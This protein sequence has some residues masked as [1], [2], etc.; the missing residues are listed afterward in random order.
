[1]KTLRITESLLC[2]ALILFTA[3]QGK[4]AKPITPGSEIKFS[5]GAN[6][7]ETDT[8]AAYSGV[9]NS[10]GAIERID[11][12]QGDLIRIYCAAVSEPSVKY[13]DYVVTEVKS[14]SDEISK[15]KIG[16]TS[17]GELG[18]RWSNTSGTSHTFYAVYPSPDANGI[19]KSIEGSTVSASLPATQSIAGSVS[20]SGLNHTANP[21]LKNM[22]MTAK[23]GPYKESEGIPEGDDVFLSFTP[24]TTAI[25]FTI[26]NRTKDA[27]TLKSV[28]LISA[29]YPLNG[30]FTVNIDSQSTPSEINLGNTTISYS[31][32]Y[33]ECNYTGGAATDA[34]RTVTINF[35][36]PVTLA[37]DDDVAKCGTL[38][39]TFFL[40]PCRN[41]DDLTFKLVKSDDS[42]M[43]TRLGYTDGS[44]ILFPCFKK[45]TVTGLLVPEGAQWRVS[46][47]PDVTPWDAEHGELDD[48]DLNYPGGATITLMT[49]WEEGESATIDMVLPVV[50]FVDLGLPSGTLW[51]D[52]NVGAASET[53]AGDYFA[54]G[55]TSPRAADWATSKPYNWANTPFNN[56]IADYDATYFGTNLS[57]WVDGTTL[58]PEYDAAYVAYG[59][60]AHIPTSSDYQELM[61][62]C[63]ITWT[64]DFEG[65]GVKGFICTSNIAGYTDQYIFLPAAGRRKDSGIS[66]ENENLRYWT[67]TLATETTV[68]SS[69]DMSAAWGMFSE[70]T[71]MQMD[72]YGDRYYGLSVRAVRN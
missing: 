33:P 32:A 8:K 5:A 14:S 34:T 45:S 64:N 68:H 16:H 41:F 12:E 21:D 65:T 36:S 15:A 66:G 1:M 53:D 52:R 71:E 29:E 40:Q 49:A 22:L 6:A 63:T 47:G 2:M 23:A 42:W 11:W 48:I 27:L 20:V 3:C 55:E 31:R 38:T 39:F 35:S 28:S 67:S 56:G 18:L 7:G 30:A 19:A 43:S 37:Y 57:N 50:T 10:A 54:W 13:A 70:G 59:N 60:N 4:M 69:G 17:P 51:A 72:G 25:R 24:L 62:N 58:K 44:G 9:T 46:F 26:T 61:D